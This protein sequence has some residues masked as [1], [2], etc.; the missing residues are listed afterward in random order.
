MNVA[1]VAVLVI[2]AGVIRRPVPASV[3]PD[4]LP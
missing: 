3:T 1:D 4:A 2:A